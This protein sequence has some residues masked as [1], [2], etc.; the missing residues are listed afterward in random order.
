M[1]TTA[2]ENETAAAPFPGTAEGSTGTSDE[3]LDRSLADLA[4][5]GQEVA[6]PA[7]AHAEPVPIR[8]VDLPGL[9]RKTARA[10]RRY[11][12]KL[13]RHR[14][15]T[16]RRVVASIRPSLRQPIFL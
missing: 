8:L 5:R 12:Q 6:L 10:E 9:A 1:A 13:E 2:T 16:V 4:P 3:V 11:Y 15:V 7:G 14:P